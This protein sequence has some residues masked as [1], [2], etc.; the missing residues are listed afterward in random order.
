MRIA[1]I[2][3]LAAVAMAAAAPARAEGLRQTVVPMTR[4][5]GEVCDLL[6][7]QAGDKCKQLAHEGSA[8]V[9]QSGAQAGIRRIV[10]A[11]DTGSDVLVSP[12]VDLV[13]DQLQSTRPTLRAMAIDGRPGVVLEVMSTWKRGSATQRTGSVVGCTQTDAIWKCALVELGACDASGDTTTSCGTAGQALSL[14]T[15]AGSAPAPLIR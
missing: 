6:R 7:A 14:V 13:G 15:P 8:T 4:A 2:A 5:D 9:Y 10:L 1:L 11:I 12:P 3:G